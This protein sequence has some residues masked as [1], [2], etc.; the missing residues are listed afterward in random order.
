MYNS[1]HQIS[2]SELSAFADGQLSRARSAQVAAH[3][4]RHPEDADRVHAYWR[5]EA[6]LY[7]A[8]GGGPELAEREFGGAPSKRAPLYVAAAALLL[9]AVAAPGWLSNTGSQ[10]QLD[11]AL[12]AGEGAAGE[13]TEGGGVVAAYAG[14]ELQPAADPFAAASRT[15]EYRIQGGGS[16]GLVLYETAIADAGNGYSLSHLEAAGVEWVDGN[17]H[18]LL[19]G[20]RSSV[21]LMALAVSLRRELSA[22]SEPAPDMLA[23][24]P[25]SGPV[26]RSIQEEALPAGVSKM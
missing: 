11:L 2:A 19:A 5:Q 6:E 12:L 9:L 25:A 15:V 13:G 21:E 1:D 18:Y 24:P 7:S 17:R 16:S 26:L 22:P 20:G 8:F 4:R 10:P 14:L 3:L 23:V